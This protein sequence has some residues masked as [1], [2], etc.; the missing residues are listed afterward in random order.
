MSASLGVEAKYHMPP[1][2]II[3][4]GTNTFSLFVAQ[5]VGG[6]TQVLHNSST[7]VRLGGGI[8]ERTIYPE[9]QARAIRALNHFKNTALALGATRILPLATSAVRNAQNKLAFLQSI[10]EETGLQPRVLSGEEEA[11]LIYR[12]VSAN[13]ELH[14]PKAFIMD[15]GGGS[16]EIII[17]DPQGVRQL[18]SIE[19]GIARI[20]ASLHISEPIQPLEAQALFAWL[21]E[22]F[23]P[24]VAAIRAEGAYTLIG[25]S[26]SFDTFSAIAQLQNAPGE[27][28]LHHTHAFDFDQ[29]QAIIKYLATLTLEQR[30]EV[31]GMARLRVDMI[32]IVCCM[33]DYFIHAAGV[34]EVI[35]SP[36]ALKDGALDAVLAGE[37]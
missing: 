7:A 20:K 26:G 27:P 11:S 33:V 16:V 25:S 32:V 8:E 28:P 17:A 21:T 1:I 18:F 4:M 36:F 34:T 30:M 22:R 9:A 12:G 13:L 14:P 31:P 3:D 6:H 10:A 2:A 23:A 24:V 15:V 5:Q 19:A 37:M 29:L 35:Y